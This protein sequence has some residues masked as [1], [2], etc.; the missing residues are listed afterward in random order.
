[1]CVSLK[2]LTAEANID[3]LDDDGD[4][5]LSTAAFHGAVNTVSLLINKGADRTVINRYGRSVFSAAC[6]GA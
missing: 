1:M 6:Q 5:P 4:S 3:D 2:L